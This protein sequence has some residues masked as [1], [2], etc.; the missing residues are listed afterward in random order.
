MSLEYKPT[1]KNNKISFIF[2]ETNI[3]YRQNVKHLETNKITN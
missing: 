3:Q 1:T 2:F